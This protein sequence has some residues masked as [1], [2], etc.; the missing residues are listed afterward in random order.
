[1]FRQSLDYAG[2]SRPI[3]GY[4]RRLMTISACAG[5]PWFMAR[6]DSDRT[7]RP[8]TPTR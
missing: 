3:E 2:F 4:G 7:S 8:Q 6:F 5:T 1:M